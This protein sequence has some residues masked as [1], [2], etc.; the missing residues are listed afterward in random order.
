MS[1]AS[2]RCA[3][4]TLF[5]DTEPLDQL[6]VAIGVFPLEIIE[7]PAAL[8]DQL[9]E[10]TARVVVFRVRLEMFGEVADALAEERDLHF[11]GSGVAL[12]GCVA[13]DDFGLAVLA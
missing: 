7:E 3:R 12:M 9:Q 4:V 11:R 6:C 2:F 10:A 5:A 13:A 1:C 8:A